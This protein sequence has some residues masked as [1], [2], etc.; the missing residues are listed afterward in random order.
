M[1]HCVP[2]RETGGSSTQQSLLLVPLVSCPFIHSLHKHL[3]GTQDVLGPGNTGMGEDDRL[4][5][6]G[7][8]VGYLLPDLTSA[9][10]VLREAG[11]RGVGT[12]FQVPNGHSLSHAVTGKA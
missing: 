11:G 8:K 6:E 12:F 10:Q 5:G 3:A 9:H 2:A 7:L 4:K 1:T